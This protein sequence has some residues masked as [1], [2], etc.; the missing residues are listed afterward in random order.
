MIRLRILVN[1][2]MSLLCGVSLGAG[3][4][5]AVI[6]HPGSTIPKLESKQVF[7]LYLGRTRGLPGSGALTLLDLPQTSP[8]RARFYLALTG[9]QPAQVNAYWARLTFSG[10]V[11]PP[12]TVDDEK[13]VIQAVVNRQQAIGYID[14]AH[15]SKEVRV[16]LLLKD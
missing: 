6:T 14:A 11:V 1:L 4:D 2:L 13:A 12:L 16:I 10:Q 15:L 5:I 9:M 3:A 7:D 8:L